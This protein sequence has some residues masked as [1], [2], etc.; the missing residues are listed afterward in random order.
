MIQWQQKCIHSIQSRWKRFLVR[1]SRLACKT[2]TK[3]WVRIPSEGTLFENQ[4]IFFYC[5][6]WDSRREYQQIKER[7][8]EKRDTKKK[9]WV[10]CSTIMH[11]LVS[12]WVI[13]CTLND[14]YFVTFRSLKPFTTSHMFIWVFIAKTN[15]SVMKVVPQLSCS[16]RLFVDC[17]TLWVAVSI[18]RNDDE[19]FKMTQMRL[20]LIC[21]IFSISSCAITH[22]R[23]ALCVLRLVTWFQLVGVVLN[24]D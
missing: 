16:G 6:L 21:L 13:N 2:Y 12:R 11:S 20:S 22:T 10:R 4:S 9:N 15:Q 7:R 1:I 5:T 3:L 18:L 24:F 8:G 19:H 14:I 17:Q 23:R